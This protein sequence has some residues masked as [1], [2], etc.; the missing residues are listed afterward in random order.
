[1]SDFQLLITIERDLYIYQVDVLE[2]PER[3]VQYHE[4]YSIFVFAVT[5]PL[6][7]DMGRTRS[8]IGWFI[9]WE[10]IFWED[11]L[12]INGHSRPIKLQLIRNSLR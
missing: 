5:E 8:P 2:E 12:S 11:L 7:I 6:P 3:A 10:A 9:K 4:L 1:M